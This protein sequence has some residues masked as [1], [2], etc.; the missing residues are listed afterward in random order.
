GVNAD[1]KWYTVFG[2]MT[3]FTSLGALINWSVGG[4]MVYRREMTLGQFFQVNQ[5]L[6]LVYMPLQWFGQLNNWFSRAMAG[7]E[8]IFEVM[9]TVKEDYQHG[10]QPGQAIS[11]RVTFQNVRFG[12]DKSNPVLKGI[13]F[14][15]EPGEMI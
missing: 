1:T 2:A 13:D 12:Y 3:F 7:A 5:L 8:R 9:D 4:Y 6:T 14:T 11:G 15:A 10:S